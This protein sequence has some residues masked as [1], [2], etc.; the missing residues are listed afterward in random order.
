M[1]SLFERLKRGRPPQ[2]EERS[3]RS[4][5]HASKIPLEDI[6]SNGPAPTTLVIERRQHGFTKKQI[7]YARRQMRIVSF[8]GQ[9][10]TV[11]GSGLSHNIEASRHSRQHLQV[12]SGHRGNGAHK[13][14]EEYK[15][16]KLWCGALSLK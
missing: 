13:E 1:V 7:S 14:D 4:R 16:D 6:L 15:E 10:S 9:G 11:A 2:I 3:N 8:K 12:L 5:R